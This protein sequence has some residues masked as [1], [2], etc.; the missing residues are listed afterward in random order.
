MYTSYSVFCL[1]RAP[2]AVEWGLLCF[3]AGGR[4]RRPNLALVFCVYFVL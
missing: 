2:G 4:T 3:Q 1:V